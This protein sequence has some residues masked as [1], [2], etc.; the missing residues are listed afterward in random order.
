MLVAVIAVVVCELF[1]V[2]IAELLPLRVVW[3]GDARCILF[4]FSPA[5]T[6]SLGGALS[7]QFSCHCVQICPKRLLDDVHKIQS[8]P[9]KARTSKLFSGLF[10][11]QH[12][13][14]WRPFI[15]GLSLY[16]FPQADK[17]MPGAQQQSQR[18]ITFS[19]SACRIV[20]FNASLCSL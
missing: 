2:Q 13:L 20:V 11:F 10:S 9:K 14:R 1:C 8:I 15:I 3:H 7:Y 5:T 12:L 19:S 17:R 4:T 16:S 18:L 6:T